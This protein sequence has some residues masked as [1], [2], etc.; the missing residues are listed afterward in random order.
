[1]TA[2]K[3]IFD[4]M[5]AAFLKMKEASYQ[6]HSGH[7]NREGTRG[8][9]CPECIRANKLRKEACDLFDRAINLKNEVFGG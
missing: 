2:E 8:L 9:N 1:M 6:S 3:Q 7:W 5:E 4:L